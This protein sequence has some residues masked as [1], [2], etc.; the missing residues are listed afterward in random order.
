[1]KLFSRFALS[2]SLMVSCA[3]P[4]SLAVTGC[5]GSAAPTAQTAQA[6]SRA[7]VGKG[8][9]GFV[10]LAGDALG[11]VD[12]RPDQRAEIEKLAQDAE[13]RHAP[14]RTEL[15]AVMLDI[16]D[17]IERGSIDK[18]ALRQKLDAAL[19]KVDAGR[20]ADE[21][22]LATLHGLLDDGQRA[23][24]ADALEARGK[25]KMEAH[26]ERHPLLTLAKELDLTSEQRDTVKEAFR[27]AFEDAREH[28]RGAHEGH[29]RRGKAFLEA[30]KKPTF[31]PKAVGPEGPLAARAKAKEDAAFTVADKVLPVLSEAQRK[32][33]ART[34]RARANAEEPSEAL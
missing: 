5:S 3:L 18:A 4:L 27:A 21:A 8:T 34:I 11:D 31:D 12:L 25:A 13:A 20:P 23:A 17:Q 10:K 9:H 24:F 1:M 33:L 14:L 15:R 16:A 19:A 2:T 30:F 26:R 22:A 6:T 29:G 32:T 7:P 28:G